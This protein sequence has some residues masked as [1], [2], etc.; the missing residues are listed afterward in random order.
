[1]SDTILTVEKRQKTGKSYA[2]AV[3]RDGK[4]PGV[5]YYHGNE[6]VPLIIEAKTMRNILASNPALITLQMDDGSTREAIIREIQ[7]DPV[8]DKIHHVD[9]MGIKRG[10]KIT[11]TVPVRWHGEAL[12]LKAGGI[13]EYLI[14]ELEIEC[15]PKHLPEKLDVDISHMNIGDSI[16]V[17]DLEFENIRILT[18]A[19]ATLI[20]IR[21]PKVAISEAVEAEE[22]EVEEE[23]EEAEAEKETE[24]EK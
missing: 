23:A 8:T 21:L 10:V 24:Q 15:L 11:A 5:F 18:G 4:I 20:N 9:F 19:D 7:R 14:R 3:R 1:M 2:R 12:G 17:G 16:H 13:L 22:E 6:A